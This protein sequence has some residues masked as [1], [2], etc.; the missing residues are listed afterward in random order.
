MRLF[1]GCF[2]IFRR[3]FSQK[4]VWFII[5]RQ[6]L[7]WY[8]LS[9]WIRWCIRG[10][11]QR[12][13]LGWGF[14]RNYNSILCLMD[15]LFFPHFIQTDTFLLHHSIIMTLFVFQFF[16]SLV[17][18]LY[19]IRKLWMLILVKVKFT[20]QVTI[21]FFHIILCWRLIQTNNKIMQFITLRLL[22]LLNNS[23]NEEFILLLCED[24]PTGSA[25]F[26]HIFSWLSSWRRLWIF[27]C[28][29]FLSGKY[30]LQCVIILYNVG[31]IASRQFC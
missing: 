22:R 13:I 29:C 10:Y 3:V 31:S 28:Y 20:S 23:L 17:Y 16:L 12:V 11:L 6:W 18:H 26:A 7:G 19:H 21:G 27:T 8:L 2:F 9:S 1:Q 4:Y 5:W 25:Y 15:T 30:H 24:C 14:R